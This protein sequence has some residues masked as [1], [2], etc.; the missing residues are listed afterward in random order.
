[1][2]DNADFKIMGKM[3]KLDRITKQMSSGKWI[4]TVL[5]GW[6]FV[7]FVIAICAIMWSRRTEFTAVI[8]VGLFGQVML[9]VQNVFKDYFSKDVEPEESNEPKQ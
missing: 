7:L 2:V 8:L 4:L 3:N 5:A 6:S 1:M 9:V